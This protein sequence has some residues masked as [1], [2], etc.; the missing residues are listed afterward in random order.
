MQP[1][2]L[3]IAGI[4][5]LLL[6]G[7]QVFV[8]RQ[9]EDKLARLGTVLIVF[10]IV[11]LLAI[12]AIAWHVG[13]AP[14]LARGAEVAVSD[15]HAHLDAVRQHGQRTALIGIGV[16]LQFGLL[17]PSLVHTLRELKRFV[18]VARLDLVAREQASGAGS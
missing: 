2:S 17:L 4:V 18:L 5:V 12:A 13:T 14:Y 3:I 11:L 16:L 8:V 1:Y 9:F 7:R 6:G 10:A 15:L